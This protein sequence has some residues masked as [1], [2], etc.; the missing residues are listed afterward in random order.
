MDVS[1]HDVR[2]AL[3]ELGKLRF[4]EM[5]VED[6][7]RD[8]AQTTHTIFNVDG[9]GLMLQAVLAIVGWE[10]TPGLLIDRWAPRMR[11]LAKEKG[12]GDRP[13][14][15]AVAVRSVEPGV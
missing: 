6:A 3:T 11:V 9:A 14:T 13:W 5:R 15:Q 10:S 1:P 12:A 4:G 2:R 8:I 7:L